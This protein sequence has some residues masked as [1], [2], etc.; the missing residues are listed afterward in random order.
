[1]L[2]PGAIRPSGRD[3]GRVVATSNVDI[4]LRAPYGEKRLTYQARNAN[5]TGASMGTT[6]TTV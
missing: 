2:E 1:M 3:E 4:V 5:R 6:A